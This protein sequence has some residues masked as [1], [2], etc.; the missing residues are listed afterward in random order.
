MV[1]TAIYNMWDI[2][3]TT[4]ERYPNLKKKYEIG[5]TID[6]KIKNLRIIERETEKLFIA[7]AEDLKDKE[8]V[9]FW[10]NKK[11]RR[12]LAEHKITP[13]KLKGKKIKFAIVD[14]QGKGKEL[15]LLKVI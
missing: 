3:E 9:E 11:H 8:T 6:V 12:Y 1:Q 15:A 13:E 2:T 5:D 7:I 4:T 14:F 10:L